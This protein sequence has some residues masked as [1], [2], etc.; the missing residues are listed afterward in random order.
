MIQTEEHGSEILALMCAP[1]HIKDP[2]STNVTIQAG[3]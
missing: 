2:T 1:L 3:E